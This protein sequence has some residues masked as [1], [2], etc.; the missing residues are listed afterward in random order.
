MLLYGNEIKKLG[1]SVHRYKKN[2]KDS[3]VNEKQAS[4]TKSK[5]AYKTKSMST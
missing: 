3:Q 1:S 5:R 4:L 2:N